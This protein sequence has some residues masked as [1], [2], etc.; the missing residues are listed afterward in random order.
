MMNDIADKIGTR[1]VIT[2][3]YGKKLEGIIYT[4]FADTKQNQYMVIYE[5]ELKKGNMFTTINYCSI[6]SIEYLTKVFSLSVH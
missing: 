6:K 2:M 5:K 3:S 1:V 4:I